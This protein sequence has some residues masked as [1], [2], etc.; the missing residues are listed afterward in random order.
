MSPRLIFD[1]GIPSLAILAA[2]LHLDDLDPTNPLNPTVLQPNMLSCV[3]KPV[4]LPQVKQ[5]PMC[6]FDTGSNPENYADLHWVA[7]HREVL[8]PFL[9]PINTP[10]VLGDGLTTRPCLEKLTLTVQVADNSGNLLSAPISFL[11][12]DQRRVND[13][14]IGL[15]DIV[16]YFAQLS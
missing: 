16:R 15:R 4:H 9:S 8:E 13:L 5:N 12:F 6:L 11:V 1:P 3:H 7:Q 10:V 14:V 2:A